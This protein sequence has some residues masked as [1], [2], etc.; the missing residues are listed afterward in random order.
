MLPGMETGAISETLF[1]SECHIGLTSLKKIELNS[2]FDIKYPQLHAMFKTA[3]WN[4]QLTFINY[5]GV[6]GQ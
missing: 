3:S 1:T 5:A 4:G 2:G 6:K